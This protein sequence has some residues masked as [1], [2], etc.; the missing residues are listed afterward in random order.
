MD[1]NVRQ[2]IYAGAVVVISQVP[3]LLKLCSLAQRVV[4]EPYTKR[5]DRLQEVCQ[6]YESDDK[7]AMLFKESLE[8]AGLVLN[9]IYWD[10]V[11]L[12]IQPTDGKVDDVASLRFG[13]GRFSCSLPV[14]RDTWASNIMCQINV[15]A[16]LQPLAH[17][18]TMQLFPMYIDKP[19]TNDS[20]EWSLEELKEARK[21]G[22]R[23]PQLPVCTARGGEEAAIM[24]D[25]LPVLIEPGDMLLF[26]SAHL[27]ASVPNTSGIPRFSTE[28]RIVHGE[29]YCQ[30]L[31]AVNADGY[32]NKVASAWFKNIR[33]KASLKELD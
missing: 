20:A 31:G 21:R 22:E 17:N 6:A 32:G 7:V 30:N 9:N 4:V 8:A 2:D 16:P 23:Y 5:S 25:G 15:W 12:R 28:T 19:V 10:R 26:S 13:T 1:K 33:T 11:R 29:D 18:R 3:S 24:Q 14:H 27:H